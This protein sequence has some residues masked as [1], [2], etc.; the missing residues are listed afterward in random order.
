MGRWISLDA[1][2]REGWYVARYDTPEQ[3]YRV[4]RARV[5]KARSRRYSHRAPIEVWSVPIDEMGSE[6]VDDGKL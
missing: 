2:E 6:G 3:P 4:I 1:V 5:G